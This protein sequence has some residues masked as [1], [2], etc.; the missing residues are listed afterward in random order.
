MPHQLSGRENTFGSDALA[1][2]PARKGGYGTRARVQ[3]GSDG[4]TERTGTTSLAAQ[5]LEGAPDAMLVTD[6]EGT[7]LLVNRATEQA[8]G[9]RREE[10]LGRR[11]EVLIPPR[12]RDAHG[13][14][15]ARFAEAPGA[16]RMGSRS[17]I[18]GLRKD[19]TEFPADISLSPQRFEGQLLVTVAIRDITERRREEESREALIAELQKALDEVKALSG[20][21]PMCAWCKRIRDD[22]GY[23][24]QLE[25]FIRARSDAEFSHCICPDCLGG[26]ADVHPHP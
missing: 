6:S 21:L 5:V 26:L 20:M 1:S 23:W 19:G 14:Y 3:P 12:F 8:F 13:Q 4:L 24:T 18:L 2:G 9:Y 17:G 15:R 7:I 16:K 25:A 11:V 22:E 10:L